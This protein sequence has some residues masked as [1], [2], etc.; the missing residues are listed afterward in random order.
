MRILMAF[1]LALVMAQ[2]FGAGQYPEPPDTVAICEQ[3]IPADMEDLQ[4]SIPLMAPEEIAVA[5]DTIIANYDADW[6]DLS[7]QGK[8]SFTGLPMKV[9]VKVYMKRGESVILSARAPIFGEVAR[10]EICQDSIVFI[11]KHSRTYNTQPL[12]GLAADPKAYMCDI[13]D[14]LLGQIAFPGHGRM[15][16]ALASDSQWIG[17]PGNDAL[18][19]PS[20]RLQ[21]QGLDYGFVMDSSCW[22]LRSFVMMI[23]NIGLVVETDYLYGNEGWTLGLKI[24]QKGKKMEGEATLSYPD[25]EAAPLEFTQLG[26]RYRKVG[27]KE[28]MKF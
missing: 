28:L 18:I 23:K 7:M 22:Q 19:Y 14:L 21:I 8:L 16:P 25:Y 17:V 24:D 2:A 3:D 10:V 4:P 5:V 13:Q 26:S 6:K 27:M 20:E 11:N 12:T 15:T 9:S 1:A